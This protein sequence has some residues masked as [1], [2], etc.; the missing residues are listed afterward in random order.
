VASPAVIRQRRIVALSALGAV[1]AAAVIG[2]A[3]VGSGGGEQADGQPAPTARDGQAGA[4]D[5]HPHLA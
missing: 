3:V 2:G 1:A 5:R 4:P